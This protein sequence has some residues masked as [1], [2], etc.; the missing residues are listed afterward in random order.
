MG[1]SRSQEANRFI[2][3]RASGLHLT[4]AHQS[5][6]FCAG[7]GSDLVLDLGVFDERFVERCC[8]DLD[9]GQRRALGSSRRKR[10]GSLVTTWPY[11]SANPLRRA[12]STGL[13]SFGLARDVARIQEPVRVL[14]RRFLLLIVYSFT[15]LILLWVRVDS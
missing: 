15:L 4:N 7:G 11:S 9:T 2:D 8:H 12:I 6:F 5:C 1:V 3:L 14:F 10:L 13:Q